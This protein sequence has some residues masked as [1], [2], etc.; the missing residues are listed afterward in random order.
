[1]VI[2][3]ANNEDIDGLNKLLLQVLMVHH[4]GRPDLFKA[5]TKKYT[6]DENKKLREEFTKNEYILKS[7]IVDNSTTLDAS[8]PLSAY[9]G[10]ILANDIKNKVTKEDG[11]GLSTNDFTDE[12]K[13]KLDIIEIDSN[14]KM[15]IDNVEVKYAVLTS[16][17]GKKFK[18]TV[19][20]DG[21]LITVEI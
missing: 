5:N 14:G 17:L 11:K 13:E 20:E 2:R 9:Q 10:A 1:M 21:S 19:S 18:L 4:N 7:D 16:P 8:K 12:Y 3:R 15:T 6:D